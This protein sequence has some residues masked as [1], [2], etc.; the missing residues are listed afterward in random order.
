[1][2]NSRRFYYHRHTM[3]SRTVALLFPGQGSQY[4]GIGKDIFDRHEIVRETY[5][6]ASDILGYDIAKLSFDDPNG[7]INLTRF[8]Q[9][10]LLTHEIACLRVFNSL[11]GN[12]LEPTMAAGHS[13]GEYSALVA[14]GALSFELGLSLVKSRGELMS[15]FGEGEMEALMIDLKSAASLAE[16]HYCGVAACNLPDQNVVGGRPEDLD[17]LVKAMTEQ[18]PRK[19]SARL[20]TEGAFHTYYM[21]EAARRFRQIL[22][23][24]EFKT[25]VFKV[26]SNFTG[27]VHD[28]DV[29]S[30]RSR[31]FLQLFNPVLWHKNL[32]TAG[33]IGAHVMIEFGGGLGKGDT[34]GDKRP[35]LEGIIKKAFRGSESSPGYHAVINQQTL[36]DTVAVFS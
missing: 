15:E 5:G 24:A 16:Q 30:I 23:Q 22:E 29:D 9:P 13:L 7:E 32:L 11:T 19:R 28:E 17:S 12:S 18:F 1:M 14:A 10:V 2:Y 25:P 35:N 26:L 27:A 20:K 36:E 34:A 4:P 8:T 21:V 3:S 31:L 33:E 6:E